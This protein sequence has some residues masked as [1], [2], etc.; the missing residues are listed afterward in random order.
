[1]D[2]L[3]NKLNDIFKSH[4]KVIIMA[5][6]DPDLDAISSSLALSYILEKSE[7][8][9]YIFLSNKKPESYTNS[10]SQVLTRATNTNYVYPS[11]YKE[12]IDENTVLVIL[13]VH[14]RDRLEYA[15]ILDDI[16]NVVILDHHIK[17]NSY[18]RDTELFYIDSTISSMAEFMVEYAKFLNINFNALLATSL[19]AGIEVDTNAFTL[20]TTEKTFIM[21]AL[22]TRMG[23]D[24]VLK[25][26]LL[27][28]SKD[29]YLRRADF[30]RSSYIL[31]KNIAI[32]P[33]TVPTTT[34]EE[35]AEIAEELLK[36]E[37]VEASFAIGQLKGNEVGIS[38][39]SIGNINVCEI[40]KLL[41]GGGH[42]TNAASQ[43][44]NST[45][46]EVETQIQE[47]LGEL[48]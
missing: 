23:A 16:K 44:S 2:T 10:V 19:L 47:V 43:I 42:I 45:V 36:F 14:Q 22:L 48:K 38:A 24:S 17:G 30:I 37:Y 41:G 34:K 28:E 13:D 21:A 18:I 5:H 8:E 26:E 25:Q 33:L 7:I 29:D 11:T 46:K 12:L 40:M 6:H 32:C 9:N 3:F 27:K 31:G 39:R 15:E 1:M 20:K 4:S 35:L